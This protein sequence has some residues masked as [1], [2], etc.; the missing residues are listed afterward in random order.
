MVITNKA[1]PSQNIIFYA[2]LTVH[3]LYYR[4]VLTPLIEK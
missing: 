3:K 1:L 4:H 2:L